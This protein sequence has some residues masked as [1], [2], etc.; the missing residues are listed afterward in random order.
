MT[1]IASI[2]QSLHL[3]PLSRAMYRWKGGLIVDNFAGGGGAST[4]I[5]KALGRSPDLAVNHDA[6]ALALHAANH[7]ETKHYN[8]SVWDINIRAATGGLPVLFGWFSP[9]CFPAG[10]LVLT[11]HGYVPIEAL[12]V[13]DWVQTHKNRWRQVTATMVSQKPVMTVR[14]RGHHG[15]RVSSEHPF[16]IRKEKYA[17]QSEWVNAGEL[18]VG[19]YWATPCGVENSNV[20]I[21]PVGGRG[22]DFSLELMRLAGY[23][24]GNGWSRVTKSRSELVFTTHQSKADGLES[25]LQQWA[26]AGAKAQYNELKWH[27]RNTRTATQFSTSHAGLVEWLRDSFGHLAENKKVPGW[28][29]QA[30]PSVKEAFL[31]GYL[32]ADGYFKHG[33]HEA[34]SVSKQLIYGLK[35]LA[36]SLG[37]SVSVYEHHKNTVIEG[38]QVNCQPSWCIRWLDQV[39]PGREQTWRD[40]GMEWGKIKEVSAAEGLETV[41]N[42]SV[43]EDE[44]YVV[45]GIVTHNCTH[46]SVAKGG[47]PVKKNIRGLAWI[48]KKWAGQSDMAIF[49]MENVKEFQTW[50]PLVAKR[51]KKTGRVIKL[52]PTDR[53][54]K[55]GNPVFDEVVAAPG[56]HVPYREQALVPD[57]GKVEGPRHRRRKQQRKYA[58]HG[59]PVG[60]NFRHFIAQLRAMGYELDWNDKAVAW[61]WGDATSRRRFIL[62]GRKDG[63]PLD[64]NPTAT[65]GKPDDPRVLAGELKPWVTAGE[66]LDFSL[67][68]PSIFDENRRPLAER[69]LQRI[70][71]GIERF[72]INAGD[73]AF[74]VKTN[75]GYDQF[76]GQSLDTPL[77]T[78]TGK[79]GT[80]VV[81]VKLEPVKAGFGMKF[82]GDSPGWSIHGPCPTITGGGA[83]VRP[84][85]AAHALGMAAVTMIQVGYGE[86][87]GQAPRVPGLDKPLGT[88]VGTNKFAAIEAKLEPV[89]ADF[90]MTID[91]QSTKDTATG[92]DEPLTAVTS[93]ARHVRV[94][95]LLKHFTGVV[96][97]GLDLPCP[98]IT[99]RDHNSV[100]TADLVEAAHIQRDFGNSVGHGADAPLGAITAGGGGK[101]ALVTSHL[102]RLKGTCQ[103]GQSN[104]EPIGAIQAQGN[105][106]AEVRAFLMK[107]YATGAIGQGLDEPIHTIRAGDTFALVTIKGVDYQIVDIGMR[108]LAP[109]ELYACQGFP[110]GYEHVNVVI[111]GKKKALRKDA[112]VR[113]VGNSVPPGMAAAFVNANVPLWALEPELEAVA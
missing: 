91:H 2:P 45:E 13:G 37:K 19:S 55:K 39:Q 54:D 104:A 30:S 66:R 17:K 75:H 108:M 82:R 23:Y 110:E 64:V 1:A 59:A 87:Q 93:K 80:G 97:Q 60:R 44:S 15:L 34:T 88:V 96:G 74:L 95:A 98:A 27:R 83:C 8:E 78:V 9:D 73:D 94:A 5:W 70:A 7:P 43:D 4:G 58:R 6:E 77:Q 90:I 24:V 71:K 11:M 106:Y 12:K 3:S 48:V 79:L 28:L 21:P 84:A 10:T 62:V 92:A 40:E 47:K 41:Y 26:P 89:E 113:M 53:K 109:H 16:Y 100:M 65:H 103:D 56:E 46:F 105:H 111:D 57:K 85:G 102:M 86:R 112:Q 33:K 35:L 52:V 20:S 25:W 61:A 69:T 29:Y 14:G 50:G 32:E 49:A 42:I 36:T 81:D 31:G 99:A 101:A 76:R 18:R 72:V 68:C 63:L 22:M 67:D 38:R 51:D 107:Y